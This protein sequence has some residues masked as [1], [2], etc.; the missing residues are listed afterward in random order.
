MFWRAA[1]LR[2]SDYLVKPA[3]YDRPPSGEGVRD[4]LAEICA[5][6]CAIRDDDQATFDANDAGSLPFAQAF[7]DALTGCA[8][9]VAKLALR[10]LDG[11]VLAPD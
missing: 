9:E 1:Y 3:S 2:M 8:N 11:R 10:E 6:S 7:V 5:D 4:P